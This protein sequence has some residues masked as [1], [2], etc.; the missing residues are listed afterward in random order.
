MRWV[1]PWLPVGEAGAVSQPENQCSCIMWRAAHCMQVPSMQCA[2]ANDSAN[3]SAIDA[4]CLC[5][6]CNRPAH[7]TSTY[8]IKHMMCSWT[9]LW[10]HQLALP[11]T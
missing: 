8:I 5:T 7:M 9:V 11:H 6:I 1:V 10:W 2:C 3:D 4:V